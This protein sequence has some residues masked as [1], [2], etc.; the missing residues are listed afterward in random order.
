M[1]TIH[2]VVG[3]AAKTPEPNSEGGLAFNLST[4]GFSAINILVLFILLK[5]I[6]F[7]PITKLMNT[8]SERI[9]KNI[10]DAETNKAQ[11]EELKNKYQEQVKK[12]KEETNY[13]M[14]EAKRKAQ[15]E[16]EDLLRKAKAEAEMILEKAR[17]E[18]TAEAQKALE[19]AKKQIAG[20]ALAAASKVIQKNMDNET[21][22]K[23]VE[24]FIDKEGAA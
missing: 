15:A 16:A 24:E 17:Q 9:K 10:A 14:D 4:I 18:G 2:P 11:A 12:I 7:G 8:R 13:I 20:L 23:L 1:Y 6:L 21:N 5:L 22:R 19:G 3:S